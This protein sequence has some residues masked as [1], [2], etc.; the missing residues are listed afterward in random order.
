MSP[1]HPYRAVAWSAVVSLLL[2]FAT[3]PSS[4]APAPPAPT[5]SSGPEDP[6]A[7]EPRRPLLRPRLRPEAVEAPAAKGKFIAAGPVSPFDG[8]S[9]VSCDL[10]AEYRKH[11]IASRGLGC[12]VFRSLDH[13]G[14]Y[15]NVPALYGMPEWMVQ[16]GI[17]GGGY[18]GKVA[19]LIP[20]IARD[21]KLPVPP[22][23]QHT[24]GDAAVLELGLKT[25]RYPGVTYAGMD[26]RYRG[27]IAHMVNLAY[28][29][30]DQAAILDNNFP[31]QYLW[32]SR[33]DF[34]QRW[35]GQGGGWAVFLLG[36]PASPVPH[37][38]ETP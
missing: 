38:S 17:A 32:M 6:L 20:R 25:G 23:A 5:P 9:Q 22:F 10:V 24:G 4:Q 36:P 33:E 29:D 11:N 35:R 30:K 14:H 18:P 15:Q 13:A 21:R 31:D 34:L 27:P 19:Q 26:S 16:S 1:A 12:C 7:R 3:A 28:L 37:N 2:L 8:K